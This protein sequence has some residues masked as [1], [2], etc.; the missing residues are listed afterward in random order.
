MPS[1]DDL[2]QAARRELA[3]RELARRNFYEFAQMVY[4][5]Y[6][7]A[8]HLEVLCGALQRVERYVA[9]Q[10]REGIGRLMVFMPPRHWKSTTASVLFPTWVLGRNP[11]ARV[12]IAS[13]NGGLA[14]GFSRRA[15][16]HMQSVEY[17]NI[18]G[19]RAGRASAVTL[20]EDSR[21]MESWDIEGHRGGMA[22]AGVGG[23]ITG[24]GANLFIID[25]PHKDRADAESVTKREAVMDWYRSTAYTRLERGA[26]MIVIQ[27][28][29]HALDL[30]GQLLAQMATDERADRWEVLSLPALAVP[31]GS[32]RVSG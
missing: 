2:K 11:D 26:A 9:T 18:F 21:S 24:K 1:R 29:W 22:A 10:G 14:F 6:P 27:T 8:R 7:Q 13:Y 23:G 30:S 25:D 31:F 16:N 19:D 4:R 3:R 32:E 20:S 12:I 28:R 15:R 5:G 17:R